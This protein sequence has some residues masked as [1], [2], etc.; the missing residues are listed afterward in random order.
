MKVSRAAVESQASSLPEIRFEKAGGLTSYAG[1][2]VFAA[3]FKSLRLRERLATCLKHVSGSQVAYRPARMFLLLLVH[4]LLGFRRL[5]GLHYYRHDPLIA[6][7]VGLKRLPHPNRLGTSLRRLDPQAIH[8]LREL[9]TDLVCERLTAEA[10]SCVTLDFDGTVQSTTGRVEGSAIGYNRIK[11]GARSYYPLLCTV[12]QTSQVF[13]LLHRPGNVHD[14][15]GSTAFM[16]QCVDRARKAC[17]D[18]RLESRM[19]GAFFSKLRLEA[20]DDNDVTFTCSVPIGRMPGLKALAESGYGWE[21]LGN[22]FDAKEV[23]YS[24][25]S[26]KK[27]HTFRFILVRVLRAKPLKGPVQLDLFEP[28]DRQYKFTAVITNDRDQSLVCLWNIVTRHHG[29]GAQERLIGEAKQSAALGIIATRRKIP[30][31]AFTLASMLAVNLTRELQIRAAPRRISRPDGLKRR[32]CWTFPTL[33]TLRQRWLHRAGRLLQPQGR[34]VLALAA[35]SS[36]RKELLD[37]YEGAA[38]AA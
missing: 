6:R 17:P 25:P 3:L 21:P 16:L 23:R 22:G 27:A 7:V 15:K 8:S 9:N 24:P 13:D 34:P 26:W 20:L 37:L 18:A 5:D 11:K 19:D 29:R 1:L 35:E 10:F 38:K 32:P 12:A 4:L 30:N 31:Q 28:I 36:T 2:V 33:A 14:S